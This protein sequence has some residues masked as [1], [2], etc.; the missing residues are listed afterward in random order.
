MAKLN[1]KSKDLQ[2]LELVNLVY[3]DL[4]WIAQQ[5]SPNAT[6][7]QLR[8]ISCSLRLLLG[9]KG[10]L[11]ACW[12]ILGMK[13]KNPLIVSS[14][15]N[16]RGMSNVKFAAACG[17]QIGNSKH[18]GLVFS[19]KSID[20]E[21]AKRIINDFQAKPLERELSLQDYMKSCSIYF[22]GKKI[23]RMHVVDFVANKKGGVHLD[24]ERSSKKDKEK[25]DV[26][27]ALVSGDF[28]VWFG[29]KASNQN[30]APDGAKDVI[31]SELMAIGQNVTQ[32]PDIK[33]MMA[34][35]EKYLGKQK[36]KTQ[37]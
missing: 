10:R 11:I 14:L 18:K 23:Q 32:S 15:L 21:E 31:F 17:M 6:D 7:E 4:G 19:E 22:E 3:E 25:F 37:S 27:D 30:K 36:R 26:L 9:H 33:R 16:L 5:T 35:C 8:R 29:G 34:E 1:N 24:F 12:K 28:K 20:D 2:N 13:P